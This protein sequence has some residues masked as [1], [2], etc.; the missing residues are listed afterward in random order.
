M[1]ASASSQGDLPAVDFTSLGHVAQGSVQ[2]VYDDI[3]TL[4]FTF[5][6]GFRAPNLAE[7]ALL[8]DSGSYFHVPNDDLGPEKSNTFEL[9]GRARLGALAAGT[10]VY[11]SLIE[12][13]SKRVETTYEGQSEV[14]GKPVV[15]NV[16]GG[17]GILFGVEAMMAV[18]FGLGISLTG[19]ITYTWGEEKVEDGPDEPLTRIPPVFGLLALRWDSATYGLISGFA[20]TSLRFASRQFRLS[21][22]DVSD[23]R[24]PE[25]GTQ[26]WAT[27]NVR[28]GLAVRERFIVGI[29]LENLLDARYRYHGSGIYAPGVN[30]VTTLELHI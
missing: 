19:H 23:V 14:G 30:A 27:W 3:A 24:I 9:L 20:E 21:A 26:G 28:V 10:S 12:D 11:V 5:S 6:Q 1:A 2:Y 29:A 22:A 25:G 15:H 7:A 8:G 16:N 13:L 18:R 17:R 4:A